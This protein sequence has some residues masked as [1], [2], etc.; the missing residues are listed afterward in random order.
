MTLLLAFLALLAT[1]AAA[2]CAFADGAIVSVDD[3]ERAPTAESA[4]ILDRREHAHRALAFAR[5]LAQLLAGA[6]AATAVLSSRIGGV[7][8][9]VLV[10]AVGVVTVVLAESAA[11]AAGDLAGIKGVARHVVGITA[12]ENLM[13]PVVAVGML[14]DRTMEALIPPRSDRDAERESTIEQFRDVVEA[15]VAESQDDAQLVRGVFS[16]SD[17]AVGDI[18]VPRVDVVGVAR[19]STWDEVLSAVRASRHARY[20]VYDGSLDS[21]VGVLHAKDLVAPV[22]AG[23][24]PPGG[25]ASLVGTAQFI[26]ATKSVDAQLRDFKA[27]RRHL[28]VVA[29]E[30]GGMAGIVTLEDALEVIVGDIR[31]E[32]D[33]EEPDVR[34]EAQRLSVSARL[35][36]E[37]LSEITGAELAVDG[38]DTVGG[39]LYSAVGGT[40]RAGDST[41]VA[42]RRLVV[43]RV[44]GRRILRVGIERVASESPA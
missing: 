8:L 9:P 15:E 32:H 20:I 10:V 27:S 12:V 7:W 31:D 3:D 42:S 29:D 14:A 6:C 40:P 17:T 13:R 23:A 33:I 39:L 24:E 44:V 2:Y 16:L 38:V 43:D 22:L 5:I 30:Y 28:A 36:L 25:W 11:R 34:Q 1:A 19:D 21:V 18:M 41:V 35:T 26:P 4:A 37:E